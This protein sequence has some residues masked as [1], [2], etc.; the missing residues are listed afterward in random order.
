MVV[1]GE[2]GLLLRWSVTINERQRI[3]GVPEGFPVTVRVQ[4]L[5]PPD[6]G[7][8]IDDCL[9]LDVWISRCLS[10]LILILGI[11]NLR[12]EHRTDGATYHPS[13]EL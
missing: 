9:P 5:K 13:E 2:L 4:M 10:S 3:E 6:G 8:V 11:G 12:H 7:R 1:R